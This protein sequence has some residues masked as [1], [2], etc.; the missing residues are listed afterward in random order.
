[1]KRGYERAGRSERAGEAR[2]ASVA[3]A[4]QEEEGYEAIFATPGAEISVM[5]P[6]VE[7]ARR[8]AW[9]E[10]YRVRT[11]T[12]LPA[13]LASNSAFS[14]GGAVTRSLDF[15]VEEPGI[16]SVIASAK[17]KKLRADETA[18]PVQPVVHEVL[19]LV[20]EAVAEEPV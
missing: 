2:R 3:P 4:R 9:N 15:A 7:N 12:P 13:R 10:D 1:M 17:S 14:A 11:G 8:S 20:K 5:L 16:Y 19:W 18:A 6:E